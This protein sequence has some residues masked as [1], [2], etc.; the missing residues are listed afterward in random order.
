MYDIKDEVIELEEELINL[1][2][3]FHMYPEL[4]YQEFRTSKIVYDYLKDLGLEVKNVAKTGVIGLLK[5][6]Q[7]GKTIILRADMDALPQKEE[8][9]IP[10]KSVNE[11]VMHACGHDGHTSMLLIAAKILSKHKKDIAGNIKFIFQPN[12]EEAGALD[13]INEGI[14]EDPKVDAAFAIHLW[15][16][17]KSGEVGLAEGPVMAA[18]EE[19]ELEIYGRAGH[20]GSPHTAIDPILPATNIIQSIQSIQTREINPL[21]PIAIMIGSINGGSG[22]NIIADKVLIG[23]TIRFLFKDEVAEKKDLLERFERVVKGICEASNVTYK[24]RY[25]PSNPSLLNDGKL[26]S[27]VR[28]ASVETF[29]VDNNFIECRNMAGEDFAEFS[30]RVPSVFYFIGNGNE[31]K[32][33]TY[34]HHHPLF[35]LDEDTLKYGVEMHVRTALDYL[36]KED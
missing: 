23:G 24:L 33:S 34:P 2:R 31:E 8:V 17:L 3:D 27:Y 20:T 7:P 30:Q 12:E 4:G 14:L 36:K 5:G 13:M 15:T 19:F 21:W 25:I 35:K 9:N 29:G 11:G 16:P 32:E 28:N 26:I 10:Y 18:L 1:R 6:E 22:R